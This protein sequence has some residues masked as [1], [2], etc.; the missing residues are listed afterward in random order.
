ME[1]TRIANVSAS[2]RLGWRVQNV[3]PSHAEID[4]FDVIGDPWDGITAKDFVQE[5]RA[6]DVDTITLT[7]NSP[8]GIV[9]DALAMYDALQ[10]HPAAVTAHVI[11][12]A[13]AASFLIQAADTRRITKNGK[14]FIHDAHALGIGNA[15]DLRMLA[16]LLDEESQNIA[17]IYQERAGG[18]VD[19]WRDRMRANDGIG[20]SYRGQEAVDIGLV[21]EIAESP[22][23]NVQPGRVA[24]QE[25][26]AAP[27]V[28]IP[29]ELIPPLASGYKPPLPT[30]FTRL[31]AA[32]LPRKKEAV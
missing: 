6:L 17:S 11:S 3:S 25:L 7:V 20:S 9:D 4:V 21:D 1:R 23:R 10:R 27:E 29:I 12:A 30:D 24:A 5:L 13:S 14:V 31:V 2:A 22:A 15:A 8:G 26:P 18:T 32:N 19:E 16:D 28:D